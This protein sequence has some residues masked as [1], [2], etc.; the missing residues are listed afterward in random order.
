MHNREM[1]LSDLIEPVDT[2]IGIR[3]TDIGA[4]AAQLP[5]GRGSRDKVSLRLT[6]N[7]S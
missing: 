5:G 4:P 3:A 2:L 1:Q 7:D 6:L